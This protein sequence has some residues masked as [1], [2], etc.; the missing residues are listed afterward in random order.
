[1]AQPLELAIYQL[2]R[3]LRRH[4]PIANDELVMLLEDVGSEERSETLGGLVRKHF[5]E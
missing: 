4:V 2:L 1:M 5:P 3:V